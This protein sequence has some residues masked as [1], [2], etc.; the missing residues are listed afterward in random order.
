MTK[1]TAM[2]IHSIKAVGFTHDDATPGLYLKVM[3]LKYGGG[4]SRSWAFRYTSP[5]TGTRR[6]LGLGPATRITLKE[7]R[8]LANDYWKTVYIEK[9]DPIDEQKASRVSRQDAKSH[10]GR[11][12][13]DFSVP[14]KKASRDST[15]GYVNKG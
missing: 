15:G 2:G 4:F 5:Q 9:R 8:T 14:L 11:K 12:Q 13:G 1:L 6:W 3:P 7:A 10:Q